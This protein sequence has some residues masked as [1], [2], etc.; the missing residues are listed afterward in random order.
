MKKIHYVTVG[1]F[2]KRSYFIYENWVFYSGRWRWLGRI[3]WRLFG[4]LIERIYD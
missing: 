1:N 4:G 2:K 3:A